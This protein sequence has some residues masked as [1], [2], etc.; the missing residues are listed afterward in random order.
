MARDRDRG[1][2]RVARDRAMSRAK[3]RDLEES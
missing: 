3:A 2:D 1:R